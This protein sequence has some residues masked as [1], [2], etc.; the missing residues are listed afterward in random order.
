MAVTKEEESRLE[1]GAGGAFLRMRR[2]TNVELE[3]FNRWLEDER[4]RST[5]AEPGFNAAEHRQEIRAFLLMRIALLVGA[6]LCDG[7]ARDP[8]VLALADRAG[9]SLGREPPDEQIL[10]ALFWHPA[11][12]AL[13]ERA[14]GVDLT[15]L[16]KVLAPD[17]AN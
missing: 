4:D 9:A 10:A 1:I 13:A 11:I 14:M 2:A 6:S 17:R 12:A 16:M 7:F 15:L 3:A 8:A 5:P